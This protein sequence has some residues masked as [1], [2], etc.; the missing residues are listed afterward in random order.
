MNV[1]SQLQIFKYTYK[2]VWKKN[3]LLC[4]KTVVLS[5]AFI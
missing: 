5:Q 2:F 1:L 4:N 3:T